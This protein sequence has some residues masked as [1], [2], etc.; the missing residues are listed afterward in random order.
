MSVVTLPKQRMKAPAFLVG[1]DEPDWNCELADAAVSVPG[2]LHYFVVPPEERGAL[3]HIRNDEGGWFTSVSRYGDII[4]DPPG[5]AVSVGSSLDDE[6][7]G[8]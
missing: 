3:H 4:L 6:E 8:Q 5:I 1:A 7:A 2:I